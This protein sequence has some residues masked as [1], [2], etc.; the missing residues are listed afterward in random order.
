MTKLLGL[1]LRLAGV[2]HFCILFASFQVP[3]RLSWKEDLAKLTPLNRKLMWVHGAF[4]VLTIVAFGTLT[5][6]LHDE[7]LELEGGR[8]AR[9]LALF[10]GVY[11]TA[12]VG[13]DVFYYRHEDWPRGWALVMGHVLLTSLFCALAATYLAL[14]FW[15]LLRA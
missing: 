4:A 13:V 1:A 9:A 11:W 14:F 7:L 15:H 10:I 3:Y 6:V 2:G 12:R 8:A 5:L